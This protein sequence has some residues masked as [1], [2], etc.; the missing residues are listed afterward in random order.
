MAA[1]TMSYL[2]CSVGLIV[3]IIA[4]PV[5]YSIERDNIANRIAESELTEIADY[6][7][8]TLSNL[9]FL[10]NSTDNANINLTKQLV[11]LPLTVQGSFYK[12]TIESVDEEASKI[13]A[14]FTD[15][16]SISSDSWL[17]P[18]LKVGN[19]YSVESSSKKI[20]ANCFRNEAGFFISVVNGV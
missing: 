3:L 8:N 4:M 9:Y 17:V 5:F 1:P 15:R 12:I 16:P 11:Y 18:G 20:F 7:S 10:A 2:I 13:T 14:S 6:T 19:S